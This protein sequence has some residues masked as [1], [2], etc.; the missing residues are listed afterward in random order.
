MTPDCAD[1]RDLLPD[2]SKELAHSGNTGHSTGPHLHFEVHPTKDTLTDPI[3]WLKAHG[4]S[5]HRFGAT[6]E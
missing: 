5:L 4:A 6:W 3:A 2:L 1:V